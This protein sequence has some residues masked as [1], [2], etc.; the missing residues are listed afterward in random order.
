[1]KVIS[2]YYFVIVCLEFVV[3]IANSTLTSPENMKKFLTDSCP[4]KNTCF[5]SC[6]IC[7]DNSP[8]SPCNDDSVLYDCRRYKVT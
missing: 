2:F 8:S 5:D 3:P 6:Y 4:Y 7:E 1:M